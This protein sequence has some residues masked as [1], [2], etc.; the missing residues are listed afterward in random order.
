MKAVV[1]P[2]PGVV[3]DAANIIAWARARIAGYKTPAQY[4]RQDF[5]PR[6]TQGLLGGAGEDGELRGEI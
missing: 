3:P 6:N 5:A 1:A 2:K 4:H